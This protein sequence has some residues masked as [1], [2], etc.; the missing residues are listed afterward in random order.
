MGWVGEEN[1]EQK[2]LQALGGLLCL[3]ECE[4]PSPAGGE[5]A[6]GGSQDCTKRMLGLCLGEVKALESPEWGRSC[7][8]PGFLLVSVQKIQRLIQKMGR[9]QQPGGEHFEKRWIPGISRRLAK[10]AAFP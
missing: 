1:P 10:W 2:R 7:S 9:R 8:A 5:W 4:Q 3:E 6:G